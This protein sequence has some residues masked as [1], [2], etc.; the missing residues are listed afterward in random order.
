MISFKL[1]AGTDVG[2]RD[3]NEDNFTVCPDL[4]QNEWIIPAD[5]QQ[6]IQLG[7]RGCIIVVADGMGG[8]NAGEV[9]S[10]IAIATV[11]KMFSLEKMPDGVWKQPSSIKDFLKNVVKTADEKV[12]AYSEEHSEAEGLGSTIVIAWIVSNKVYICWLGDSR[13]YAFVSGK[14]IGRLSK[15]HSYVQ[16]LVDAGKFT[17][18]EAMMHPNSNIITRSLG[19][20]TQKAKPEVAEYALE[21]GEIILLCSDGLCGVCKDVEIGEIIEANKGDLKICKDKLTE[22]AL[23]CGGSDNITIALLQV[24]DGG[25]QNADISEEQSFSRKLKL[26]GGVVAIVFLVLATFFFLQ[27]KETVEKPIPRVIFSVRSAEL[28]ADKNLFLH[29]KSHSDIKYVFLCK[30]S[31]IKIVNNVNGA[32]VSIK[33]GAIFESGATSKLV[34][35]SKA[36]STKSDTLQLVLKKI[37][38][39][40]FDIG[41]TEVQ[42]KI[43]EKKESTPLYGI[44][45]KIENS[46][47]TPNITKSKGKGSSYGQATLN[48]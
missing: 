23:A 8:Q 11:Q 28:M 9:A 1:F 5:H 45:K 30:D 20:S 13:A 22:A 17:E 6:V 16:Q 42:S 25:E 43:K 3:N 31:R 41:E 40:L 29:V 34:V 7:E 27:S 14:G 26:W 24:Y 46:D 44:I 35:I 4:S 18:E 39:S 15:D 21:K 19:D 37:K 38:Q 10:A 47:T 2:L 32:T 36:D 48:H 33:Q 12:K